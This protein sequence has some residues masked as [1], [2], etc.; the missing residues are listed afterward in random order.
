MDRSQHTLTRYLNNEKTHAVIDS[1]LFKKLIHVKNALHYVE[2][3]KAEIEHKE[4]LIVGF[5]ILQYAKLRVLELGTQ[6]KVFH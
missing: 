5:F 6:L 4:S 1:K 3:A 2:L